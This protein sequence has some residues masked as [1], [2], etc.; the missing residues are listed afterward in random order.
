MT[1]I[2][3]V[4]LK[5]LHLV[6]ERQTVAPVHLCPTGDTRSHL[7]P[8]SKERKPRLKVRDLVAD[9]W[10]RSDQTHLAAQDI[11]ALRQLIQT[12]RSEKPANRRRAIAALALPVVGKYRQLG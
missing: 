9:V 8:A 12:S 11:P 10:P 1:H 5:L 7:S 2:K 6:V 4:V 3:Q